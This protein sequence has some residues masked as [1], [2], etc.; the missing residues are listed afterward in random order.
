VDLAVQINQVASQIS[1][2]RARALVV[3][4]EQ[5]IQALDA[6]ANVRLLL[7][8]LMLKWPYI[9]VSAV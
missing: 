6:Y 7:E 8:S 1:I 2:E 3:S 5:G 9:T 4:H